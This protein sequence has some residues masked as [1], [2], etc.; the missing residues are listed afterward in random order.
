VTVSS[1]QAAKIE[2]IRL[3][4]LPRDALHIY[5]GMA[6]FIAVALIFRRSLRDPRPI[7]A[8]L[9]VAIAGEVWDLVDRSRSGYPPAVAGGWH[10]LWNT[11]F[12]PSV[13]FLLARYTSLLR[14]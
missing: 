12:W 10:D 2:L 11:L 13:L 14:R 7:A 9:L 3:T 1:F 5:V 8:V 4:G 6:V